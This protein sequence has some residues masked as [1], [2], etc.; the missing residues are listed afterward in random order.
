MRTRIITA[1]VAAAIGLIVLLLE[2]VPLIS[3]FVKAFSENGHFSL[4]QFGTIA[5]QLVYTT[6][7]VN[8][9]WVTMLS[10]IVGL[11]IDFFLALALYSDHGRKK[12]LYLSL[13]NLTSTFSGVPLRCH[14]VASRRL[15]LTSPA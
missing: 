7:I 4:A 10:T 14:A 15:A 5:H 2:C 9:L 13:L 6:A 1:V 11:V 8:S 3:M 12:T